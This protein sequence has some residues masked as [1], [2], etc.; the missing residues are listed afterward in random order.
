MICD[1]IES[2]NESNIKYIM[3]RFFSLYPLLYEKLYH[4]TL[5]TKK[6]LSFKNVTKDRIAEFQRIKRQK[7]LV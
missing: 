2:L 3:I 6:K 4:K 5:E 7:K 1:K